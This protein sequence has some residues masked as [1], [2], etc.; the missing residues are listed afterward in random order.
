[1]ATYY[2]D[3]SALVKRYVAEAGSS[4]VQV[5]TSPA[6]RHLPLTSRITVVEVIGAFARRRREAA[7]AL[8][9]YHDAVRAFRYDTFTQYRRVEVDATVTEIAGELVERYPLRAYDAVQLASAIAVNRVLQRLV[10]SPVRFLS[11]DDR[12]VTAA[13]AEGLA[14]ENPSAQS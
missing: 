3:S 7:L 5:I 14:A 4:N 6:A 9:D 8:S 13:R 1:M 2:L 12:L 11:S 10:I